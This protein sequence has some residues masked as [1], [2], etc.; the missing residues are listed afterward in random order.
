MS[1]CRGP[2]GDDG[3]ASHISIPDAPTARPW[4][5]VD[6][7][8]TVVDFAPLAV[9]AITRNGAT[10]AARLT[11]ALP[12]AETWVTARFADAAGPSAKLFSEPLSSLIA[13]QFQRC[14][15]LVLVLAL[16]AAVRLIAP[17]LRDKRIDP[18]V[19]VVD[20]GGRFAVSVLSGH[21]GGGNVLA[22]RVAEI[23]GAQPVITTASEAH[24]LPVADLIGSEFGWTIEHPDRLTRLAATLVNGD[25]VALYQDAGEADWYAGTLPSHVVPVTSLDQLCGGFTAAIVITDRLVERGALPRHAVVYRPRTLAVGIGCSR[26]AAEEEIAA[27]VDS[28]LAEAGLS[29]ACIRVVASAGIKRDEPGLLGFARAR[30]LPLR[31]FDAGTL[32]RVHGQETPSEIVRAAVGTRG[33]CEPAALLAA[34]ASRL[35]VPKHKSRKVTVAVARVRLQ[36]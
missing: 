35:L 17:H 21:I 25:H 34:G 26:G 3:A 22:R 29:A 4:P 13:E 24:G 15:G 20:D 32:D 2:N 33:V 23:L 5:A 30:A 31:F 6:A 36:G 10:L 12:G 28:T 1:A 18:A 14:R 19:V 27:L 16:G 9:V 8:N 11:G 7:A